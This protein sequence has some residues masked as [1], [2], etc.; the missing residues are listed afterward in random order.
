M[1]L[2]LDKD[3]AYR[4]EQ[5]EVDTLHSRLSAIRGMPGNPMDVQIEKFGKATAFSVKK[6][7][8]PSFNTVKGLSDGDEIYID[9]IIE[10]YKRRN[11]PARFELTPANASPKLLTI[12]SEKGFYQREFHSSLYTSSLHDVEP[13]AT[14]V[15]IR[16]LNKNE[17]DLFA[18]IYIKGF[19]L[20]DFVKGGIAQNNAVL[21]DLENWTFY[22]AIVEDEPA[23]IGVIFVQDK[24]ATL[25]AAATIP[26]LRNKGVHRALINERLQQ[27]AFQACDLAV[28]QAKYASISQNNMER[29]GLRIAYTKAI[30]VQQE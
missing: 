4:V 22:L 1:T 30:W 26:H 27:A 5:S 7:P 9:D 21:Y 3:L 2:V 28:G 17:F 24:I 25:A 11:I 6:I 19:G 12:L 14:Q 13:E 15:A 16:K 18:E 29:S 10:Y 8:G 20:P 23:G